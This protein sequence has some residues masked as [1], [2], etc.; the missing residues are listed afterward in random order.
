MPLLL[1]SL[2]VSFSD[3]VFICS[4]ILIDGGSAQNQATGRRGRLPPVEGVGAPAPQHRRRRPR[5]LQ[6]PAVRRGVSPEAAEK[7]ARDDAVCRGHILAALSDRVLPDY[8]RHATG[9]AVWDAVART[10]D[11]VWNPVE[12]E[13]MFQRFLRFQFEEDADLLEQLA[14]AEAMAATKKDPP[15]LRP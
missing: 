11:L 1:K 13:T 7:W 15:A 3:A 12:V 10:Y 14:H 6:G 2:S 9:R 8:V 5:A 4:S